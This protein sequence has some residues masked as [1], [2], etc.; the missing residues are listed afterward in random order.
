MPEF[1]TGDHVVYK[2]NGV[3]LVED[4]RPLSFGEREKE[5]YILRPLN[6]EGT[7]YV[8]VDPPEGAAKP[9]KVPTK[10][11]LDQWIQQAEHSN[12][13]W[14]ENSKMRI[15]AFDRILSSGNRGDILWLFKVLSAKK[16]EEALKHKKLCANEERILAGAEKIITDEFAF[17]LDLPKGQIV[18]YILEQVQKQ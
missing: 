18:D 3:C 5:Y 16:E 12:L 2:N 7:V 11:D 14:I 4:I 9:K 6:R 8:P 15:V 13:Q 1:Q 10:A 17:T